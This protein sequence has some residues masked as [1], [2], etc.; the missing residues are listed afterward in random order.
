M[1]KTDDLMARLE[2]IL[3]QSTQKSKKGP[4]P[5]SVKPKSVKVDIRL[6]GE[7]VIAESE[8]KGGEAGEQKGRGLLL[9]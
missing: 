7:A 8:V 5:K 3:K 2:E 4:S 6:E 9:C 1:P